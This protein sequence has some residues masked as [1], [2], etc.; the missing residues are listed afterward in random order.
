MTLYTNLQ[1]LSKRKSNSKWNKNAIRLIECYEK[2][3]TKKVPGILK[4]L[5]VLFQNNNLPQ[6]AETDFDHEFRDFITKSLGKY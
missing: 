5:N 4:E 1:Y 3:Q 2:R 6:I